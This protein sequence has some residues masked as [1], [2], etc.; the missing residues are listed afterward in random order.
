MCGTFQDWF[1]VGIK[2]AH[3]EYESQARLYTRG[4]GL[5]QVLPAGSCLAGALCRGQGLWSCSQWRAQQVGIRGFWGLTAFLCLM[6][7]T[8][9]YVLGADIFHVCFKLTNKMISDALGEFGFL[10]PPFNVFTGLVY[11]VDVT[12]NSCLMPEN[13]K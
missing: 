9:L 3:A 12:V 10:S 1:H 5:G 13:F 6:S 11:T 4:V 8:R 7:A 2:T